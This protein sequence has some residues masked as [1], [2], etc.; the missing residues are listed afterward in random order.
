MPQ[1][2]LDSVPV[3][4]SGIVPLLVHEAHASAAVD[5]YFNAQSQLRQTRQAQFRQAHD[6]QA[7]DRTLGD[8][9]EDTPYGSY[10][11][12]AGVALIPVIG[13]LIPRGLY[14]G[15]CC[16]SYE[17]LGAEL[18]RAA[19]DQDVSEIALMIDSP[20]GYV[21]GIDGAAAAIAAAGAKKTV[22]AYVQGM[23]CS[24]AYWLA[25]ACA[26]IVA[27]PLS[28]LGSIGVVQVHFDM[29]RMLDSIGLS[30]TLMHAGAKKVDG[31]P[32]GPLSDRVKTE[33]QQELEDLRMAFAEAVAS[34]RPS[35]DVAAVLA[36]EAATYRGD[37]VIK[38]GLADRIGFIAEDLPDGDDPLITSPLGRF[39]ENSMYTQ[40]Q[41]NDA[42]AAA[43]G[44]A[45]IAAQAEGHKAGVEEGRIAGHAAGVAE[46]KTAGHAAG[47]SEG[48]K[49][50]ATAERERFTAI[51]GLPEAKKRPTAAA[52]VALSTEMSAD[53]AKV[54][55]AKLP[56]ERAGATGLD[57]EMAADVKPILGADGKPLDHFDKE[58]A[59][60]A[61]GEATAKRLLGKK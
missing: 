17:A 58:A 12:A 35:L 31:N 22:T 60:Y 32:Y 16:T 36:T 2:S 8:R 45:K 40:A 4:R 37:D 61:E 13:S 9:R 25:C 41:L 21:T 46:G 27:S 51:R 10:R 26:T 47:R 44:T 1:P 24:A 34:G 38:R 14:L 30:V 43:V 29:S 33:M 20:G 56:E 48:L 53:V 50:G 42:I 49:E 57:A 15:G 11:I 59:A 6:P 18:R 5:A 54:F 19:A 55:L 52:E 7:F 39:M 3:V 23:C 28:E